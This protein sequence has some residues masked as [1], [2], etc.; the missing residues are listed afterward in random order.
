MDIFKN[1]PDSN[2]VF[3]ILQKLQRINEPS[4]PSTKEFW[5]ASFS[6]PAFVVEVVKIL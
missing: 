2:L 5:R 3:Q 4:T 1:P 6:W